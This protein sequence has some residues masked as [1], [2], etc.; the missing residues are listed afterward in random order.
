MSIVLAAENGG[1]NPLAVEP[2]LYVWT[3][4]AFLT[5][6]FALAKWVFPKLQDSLT[7]RENKIAEEISEA[8]KTRQ[9]A[10]RILTDYKAKVAAAREETAQMID[11]ARGSAEKVRQELVARAEG[12]A[13]LIV[14]KARRQLTGERERILTE[15]QGQLAEWSA[16]IASQIVQKELS[17]DAHLD[18]V[19]RFIE[20][21]RK[22]EAA[23]K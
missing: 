7:D 13:R 6:L 14:D 10:E 23:T 21:V 19:E 4:L 2:G 12:D 11:E 18:M 17:P 1:F 16:A 8:E 22:S 5:V 15:L 9:E 3:T 20:D